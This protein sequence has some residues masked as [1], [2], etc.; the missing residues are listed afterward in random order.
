MTSRI[1]IESWIVWSQ[2][3]D[4]YRFW[5]F[6]PV[7]KISHLQFNH[8]PAHANGPME[9]IIWPFIGWKIGIIGRGLDYHGPIHT[10][11]KHCLQAQP[12][13]WP[14]LTHLVGWI[15]FNFCFMCCNDISIFHYGK[16]WK[17]KKIFRHFWV[18]LGEGGGG[19]SVDDQ[20][21]PRY[22]KHLKTVGRL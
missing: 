19:C 18:K 17:R 9:R 12:P 2:S 10:A 15:V 5:Y 20:T 13:F 11:P 21:Y 3:I 1:L 7:H 4:T 8:R 14:K 6:G 22:P 16:P